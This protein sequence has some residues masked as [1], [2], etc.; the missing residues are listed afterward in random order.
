MVTIEDG[1]A[2]GGIGA[3]V[4]Q[5]SREAGVHTPI[6]SVGIPLAFLGHATRA[7]IITDLRL[8]PEDIAKDVLVALDASS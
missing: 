7:Q 8:R 3:L 5:R 4:A 1:L 2:D 6:Q